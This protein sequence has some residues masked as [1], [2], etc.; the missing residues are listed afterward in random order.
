[1]AWQP[2]RAACALMRRWNALGK[3]LWWFNFNA[4]H[5]CVITDGVGDNYVP[6]QGYGVKHALVISSACGTWGSADEDLCPA[7]RQH[8]HKLRQAGLVSERGRGVWGR[9]RRVVL[10]SPLGPQHVQRG[11]GRRQRAAVLAL[12]RR[13]QGT[14]TLSWTGPQSV[15]ALREE[16]WKERFNNKC[17][18]TVY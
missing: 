16:W 18:S 12:G 15:T 11:A 2:L 7:L 3:Q 8:G 14:Q 4:V 6:G 9:G 17:Q 5:K 13:H 10:D 1:M